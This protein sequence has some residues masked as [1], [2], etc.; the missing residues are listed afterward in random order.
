[1]NIRLPPTA[2]YD[3]YCSERQKNWKKDC[4]PTSTAN[5]IDERRELAAQIAKEGERGTLS[6]AFH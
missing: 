3:D 6:L 2:E 1:M 4:N 5:E